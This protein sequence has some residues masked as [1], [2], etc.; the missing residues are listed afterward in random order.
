[1]S[2]LAA[3]QAQLGNQ[4]HLLAYEQ[5]QHKEQIE[6]ALRDLPG[7]DR[8]TQIPITPLPGVA[9]F[10][11]SDAK[12]TLI[13][14]IAA[15]DFI[16]LHG[17]WEPLLRVS[18]NIA[19]DHQTPYAI[20]P[21]GMLNPWSL[22]QKPWKKKLA[23]KLGYHRM[24]QQAAFLH[25]LNAGEQQA[26]QPLKLSS[27]I[28]VIPNGISPD[29][30]ESLPSKGTFR[31]EHPTLG[32]HPF[33]L[34]LSRLHIKK[35]LDYLAQAFS[36]L[37]T[38]LPNVHL[39]VAGPDF[40]GQQAFE[41]DIQNMGLTDRVHLTGP[42]YGQAKLAALVDAACFCLPSRDEGFSIAITEALACRLPVVI[43]QGCHF[44][45]VAQA[46]AGQVVPLDYHAIAAALERI[47]ADP[48]LQQ[49]MGNAGRT[50]VYEHFTWPKIAQQTIT[51]Y[52]NA[53]DNTPS[54]DRV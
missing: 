6:L 15:S 28:Q 17:V 47:L 18:A 53:L 3:A 43:S 16:H 21:H 49:S 19:I 30:F 14:Q 35:G 46:N 37:A 31:Q 22:N 33:I 51:A 4:V 20:T 39:V 25:L 11:A 24:L 10:T 23:L 50:F 38:N 13:R 44:P 5:P 7:L 26:L 42:I 1:V 8:I 45:Q 12:P 32:D 27:P 36:Q 41:T 40:G 54:G 2:R 34:F 52:Q 48:N 29:E 9:R